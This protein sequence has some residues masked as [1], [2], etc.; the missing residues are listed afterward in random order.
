[1]TENSVKAWDYFHVA[2]VVFMLDL[3]DTL[4]SLT[5]LVS[6]LSTKRPIPLVLFKFFLGLS[7]SYKMVLFIYLNIWIPMRISKS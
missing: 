7:H 5:H 2:K 6:E 1:M 3:V 4:W